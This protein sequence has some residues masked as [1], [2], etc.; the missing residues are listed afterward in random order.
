MK[1]ST[2]LTICLLLVALALSALLGVV[3]HRSTQQD[4]ES[5]EVN[6]SELEKYIQKQDSS[7]SYRILPEYTTRGR[8]DSYTIFVLNMT[9][10]TWLSSTKVTH[11]KWWHYMTVIIPDEITYTDVGCLYVTGDYN[12]DAPRNPLQDPE[13]R[14][15][16]S[17][18]SRIGIVCAMQRQNPNGP[19]KFF[20]D[21]ENKYRR[22]DDLIAYTFK[23]FMEGHR[24]DPEAI[25]VLPMV[26]SVVR[27]MDTITDF[28]DQRIQRFFVCGASK[29]G[30]ATWLTAA[31][32]DRVI[33]IMPLVL[34]FL[35][36]QPNFA[37]H[38]RSMNGWSWALKDYWY[39]NVT[40]YLTDPANV[41][42][43]DIVDPFSYLDKLKLPKF[44]V[45]AGSD[46]FFLP[47]DAHYFYDK[48][49]GPTYLRVH[50]NTDHILI[51]RYRELVDEAVGFINIILENGTLPKLT[52]RRT[53]GSGI[54]R[55]TVHSD[56][57]PINI[58]AWKA[59][60]FTDSR[61]DF[62]VIVART[63][64]TTDV[65]PQVT[66][67]RDIG[68]SRVGA[69]YTAT[70]ETPKSGWSCFFIEMT[71]PAPK[72]SHIVVTTEVNIIPDTFPAE[73]CNGAECKGTLV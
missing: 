44:I 55:I 56:I 8:D 30:W 10:Q 38:Y 47:D 9:S 31:V 14:L 29:R 43:T 3:I 18:S 48:M 2:I 50:P 70:V 24:D 63:P 4:E 57:E 72:G 68:V 73:N 20:E 41:I 42:L 46:E 64:N 69:N 66:V 37:H 58:T 28:A 13:F 49:M 7:Y 45:T 32:D 35:N 6:L 67:Y 12:S 34:D 60:T 15:V 11:T 21:P 40:N 27:A 36:M 26:K 22:S 16:A 19:I 39:H 59:N 62:R 61:R 23:Y 33:G 17:L 1:N 54:G 51:G 71:F 5:T 53:D 52:W 25:L 65:K